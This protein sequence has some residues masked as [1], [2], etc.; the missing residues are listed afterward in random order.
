[1]KQSVA[2]YPPAGSVYGMPEVKQSFEKA[3]PQYASSKAE[4]VR[5]DHRT[6]APIPHA[7]GKFKPRSIFEI[8]AGIVSLDCT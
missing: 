7:G 4:S 2:I 6:S 3:E 8:L 5:R 1:L